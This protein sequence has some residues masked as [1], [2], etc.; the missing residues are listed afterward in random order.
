MWLKSE[1]FEHFKTSLL[2]RNFISFYPQ[3]NPFAFFFTRM[4]RIVMRV[5]E[6]IYCVQR[7]LFLVRGRCGWGDGIEEW[8]GENGTDNYSSFVSTWERFVKY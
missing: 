5:S 3:K 1:L 7:I 8:R 6:S 2:V 4:R